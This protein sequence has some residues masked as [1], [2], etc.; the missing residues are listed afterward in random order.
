M[1]IVASLVALVKSSHFKPRIEKKTGYHSGLHV[2]LFS[3]LSHV[4][5]QSMTGGARN[6]HHVTPAV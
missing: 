2:S 3:R 4:I 1:R 5:L 6:E